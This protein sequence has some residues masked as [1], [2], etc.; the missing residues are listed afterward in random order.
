[1][2]DARSRLLDLLNT[3]AVLRQQVTLASGQKS[4]YY[5]DCRAILLHG[6]AATLIGQLI[7]QLAASLDVVALGG[8]ESAAL[9]I[10]AATVVEA[11][12]F[13]KVLEGFYVRKEAKTHGLQKRIEGRLEP[14]WRVIVVEDVMTTGASALSAVQTVQEAGAQVVQVVCLVDRL[15]GA[16]EKF[17]AI[18][19]PLHALYT[20]NDLSI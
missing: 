15:Q 11:Y 8:P 18:G 9:P 5:I 1:M 16:R 17:S 12:R 6:E 3:R 14:G 2:N 13:G 4:N 10:T 20:V 7:W 19:V